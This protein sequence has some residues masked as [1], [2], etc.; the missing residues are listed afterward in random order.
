[1]GRYELNYTDNMLDKEFGML[2]VV[3]FVGKAEDGSLLYDAVCACEP[4]LVK[5]VKGKYLRAGRVK[6]CGC[7]KKV[8]ARNVSAKGGEAFRRKMQETRS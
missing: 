8:A 7:L 1:M 4:R 2:T 6:S 5:N 3:E